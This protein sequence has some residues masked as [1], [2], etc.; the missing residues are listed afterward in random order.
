MKR[1]LR[2]GIAFAVLAAASVVTVVSVRA[3]DGDYSGAY[4]LTGYFP[5][6]GEGLQPGS[7]VVYRGVQVGRVST[8]SL[9]GRRARV[10]LLVDPSFQV[11]AGVKATIE[12]VNLFGAE[13][14]TLR[15]PAGST[16]RKTLSAGARLA[17]TATSSELGDLF[18]AAAP[19]LD[20]ITRASLSSVVGE[21][22]RATNG[23]GPRI[24]ASVGAGASLAALFDK[25]LAAQL[26]AFD[27]FS[28]FAAALAPDG[29]SLDGVARQDNVALVA[30]DQESAD[31]AK[32]LVNLTSFSSELA[33]LLV[34]YRPTIDTLLSAGADP[35]RV[36]VAQQTELGQVIA[37]AYRYAY[38]V[39]TAGST[40]VL[41]TGSRFVY[42]T[43]FVMFTEV[44]QLV[45]D[46]IA[47]PQAGLSYLEPLQQALA[48]A[49]SA[50]TCKAQFDEFTAAQRQPGSQVVPSP[51]PATP[52]TP[53]TTPVRKATNALGTSVFRMLGQ[54]TR[55]HST[56]IG[57]Y[58]GRL[59]GG[60]P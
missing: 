48:G 25:T 34:D 54:P 11:P 31:Y 39:G 12:P 60:T 30:F 51:A 13:Q 3:A 18:T 59:L 22:A 21:L 7:A 24:K 49:G 10:T 16:D 35:A 43:T 40:E 42:F 5:R 9:A 45:C 8:I 27:S 14:V 1:S 53:A 6:A 52:A 28:R 19:L 17:D 4:R 58:L 15:V 50:F 23:E 32:L 38:K 29:T 44:N 46:M 47:P 2:A 20:K 37:G 56:S 33:R 57:A 36:L 55:A 26:A 41:P